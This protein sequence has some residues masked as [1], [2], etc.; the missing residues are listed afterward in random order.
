MLH[1]LSKNRAELLSLSPSPF[2]RRLKSILSDEFFLE[3][4]LYKFSSMLCR[5]FWAYHNIENSAKRFLLEGVH[6]FNHD[7]F[8][9]SK[10]SGGKNNL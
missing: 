4:A 6:S 2:R 5:K 10:H 9:I 7:N 8:L 3:A 1:Q